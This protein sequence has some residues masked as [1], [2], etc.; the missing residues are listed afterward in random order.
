MP[1]GDHWNSRDLVPDEQTAVLVGR[2][3]L[4]RYFGKDVTSRFE[5]YRASLHFGEWYV[6]GETEAVREMRREQERLG[7][8]VLLAMRGGG[9][10]G[11]PTS[12][13]DGRVRGIAFQR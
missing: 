9:M 4:D 7:D 13:R 11:L 3:I 1:E 10:P 6:L 5:P 2:T 8:K 12:A